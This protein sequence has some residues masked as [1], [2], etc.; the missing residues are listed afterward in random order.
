MKYKFKAT[1]KNIDTGK[2][3]RTKEH[4]ALNWLDALNYFSGKIYKEEIGDQLVK[5]EMVSK[6]ELIEK[7]TP[8]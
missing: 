4:I 3:E 7:E 2:N 5:I 8:I 6:I 1:L